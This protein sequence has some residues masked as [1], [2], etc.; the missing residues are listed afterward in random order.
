MI[1]FC[2]SLLSVSR[3]RNPRSVHAACAF[4]LLVWQDGHRIPYRSLPEYKSPGHGP[5]LS[6]LADA[7]D[8]SPNL[9]STP[10][11]TTVKRSLKSALT[12]PTA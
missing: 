11:R 8:Q 3:K 10:A 9:K 7:V 12:A 6:I 2:S 1:G 5:G 4:A